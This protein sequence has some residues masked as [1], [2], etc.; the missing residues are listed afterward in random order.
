VIVI[1]AGPLRMIRLHGDAAEFVPK[2]YGGKHPVLR[3]TDMTLVL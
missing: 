3:V 1:A 2:S